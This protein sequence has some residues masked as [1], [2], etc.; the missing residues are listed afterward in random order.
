MFC[1][2]RQPNIIQTFPCAYVYTRRIRVF[3]YDMCCATHLH[4]ERSDPEVYPSGSV[5]GTDPEGFISVI[6]YLE[7]AE[8]TNNVFV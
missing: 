4:R 1:C 5:F 3:G 7:T 8:T 6:C 2:F